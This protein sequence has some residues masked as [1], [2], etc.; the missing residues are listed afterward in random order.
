MSKYVYEIKLF[1]F[2]MQTKANDYACMI[3]CFKSTQPWTGKGTYKDE[4]L[5]MEV[6]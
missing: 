2:I 5:I 3:Q 1:L 6:T 4:I